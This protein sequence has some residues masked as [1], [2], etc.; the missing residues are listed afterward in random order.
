MTNRSSK[1]AVLNG[2][3]GKCPACGT[4]KMF[5]RYIKVHEL[6]PSCKTPLDVHNVDDAPTWITLVVVLHIVAPFVMMSTIDWNWSIWLGWIVWPAVTTILCLI[7]LPIAKGGMIGY[8]WAH[9]LA[10]FR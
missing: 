6:C 1:Q 3:K 4:G 8:Q 2:C 9:K 5:Y 10:G 7:C